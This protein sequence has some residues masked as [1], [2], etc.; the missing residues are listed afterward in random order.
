MCFALVEVSSAMGQMQPS[1]QFDL[2]LVILQ[3][4]CLRTAKRDLKSDFI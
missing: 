1:F 3:T 2:I 4:G